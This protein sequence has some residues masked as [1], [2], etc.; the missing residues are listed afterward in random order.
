MSLPD[1]LLDDRD[2]L[3]QMLQAARA[4]GVSPRRFLGWEPARTTVYDHNAAGQVVRA[5]T[6]QEPEWDDDEDPVC[7]LGE[8]ACRACGQTG[9]GHY[10]Y[11]GTGDL[12]CEACR[13]RG[14][15]LCPGCSECGRGDG[16]VFDV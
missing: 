8:L 9:N 12:K 5:T 6:T 15:V 1:R 11:Q 2:P 3:R 13:G 10:P 16:E 4:W 14:V 7:I